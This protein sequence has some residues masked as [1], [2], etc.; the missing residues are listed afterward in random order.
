[1][2]ICAL[3]ATSVLLQEPSTSGPRAALQP[4]GSLIG[5]WKGTGIPSGTRREQQ[6]GFWTEK[7]TWEWQ[8]KGRDAWLTVAF[9]DGKHFKSGELRWLPASGKYRL[10]LRTADKKTL[11]FLGTLSGKVLALDR[12]DAGAPKQRLVFSLLHDNRHLYRLEEQP[13]GRNL[14]VRKYQVGCTKEGVPFAAGDGFPEC[15]VSGGQGTMAVSYM[16]KTY[17]VCCGGCRTEF[18]AEPEKY[19][20]EFEA[21]RKKK[22]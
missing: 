4:L 13:Q 17:Y 22:K 9:T 18:L 5:T 8:F 19:I 6:A 12:I 7:T 1:M 15:I 14:F 3:L 11:A 10:E 16:G 2:L 21:A 20:R